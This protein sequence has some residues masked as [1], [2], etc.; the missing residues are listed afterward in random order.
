M[1]TINYT[2]LKKNFRWKYFWVATKFVLKNL[3]LQ[4]SQQMNSPPPVE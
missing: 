2:G 1:F 4:H 3:I